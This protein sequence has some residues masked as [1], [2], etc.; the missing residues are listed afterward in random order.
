MNAF[1]WDRTTKNE[2]SQIGNG[3]ESSNCRSEPQV[4]GSLIV[5]K[6]GLGT[7]LGPG[8]LAAM[9]EDSAKKM[10]LSSY[11][12]GVNAVILML[13]SLVPGLVSVVGN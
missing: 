3:T 2:L 11:K 4:L 6:N 10:K 1:G 12:V 7:R 9:A 5:A 13:S 8:I